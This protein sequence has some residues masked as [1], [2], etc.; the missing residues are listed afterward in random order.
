[1]AWTPCVGPILGA[2][3]ALA[4]TAAQI[5]R[6]ILLLATYAAGLALPFFLSAVAVNSFFQFSQSFRRYVQVVHVAG[7]FLLVIVGI[8]LITDYITLLNIYAIRFTPQWLIK[9]L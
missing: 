5:E 6:G 1:M 9:K 7:G 2:I 3:L 8:L 4:G